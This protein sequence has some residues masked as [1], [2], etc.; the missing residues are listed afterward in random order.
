MKDSTK[1][2]LIGVL[3]SQL[4]HS[5]RRPDDLLQR[6][7]YIGMKAAA[8]IVISEGY[9]QEGFITADKNGK[10]SITK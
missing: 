2:Y 9:T 6:M 4:A 10:H 5:K 3:D 7:Y 8:D 1:K